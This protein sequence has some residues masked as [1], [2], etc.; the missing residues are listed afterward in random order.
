MATK[1]EDVG[2][3]EEDEDID[4]DMD[5]DLDEFQNRSRIEKPVSIQ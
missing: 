5:E 4:D 1:G 2:D 3:E